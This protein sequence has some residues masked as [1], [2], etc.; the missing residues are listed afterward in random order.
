MITDERK[1]NVLVEVPS[2]TTH[3][4]VE[5]TKGLGTGEY[6][7]TDSYFFNSYQ[8]QAMIQ[9]EPEITGATSDGYHTF[10]EL[11]FHRMILFSVI[12]NQNKEN[13]WKARNH[14][15]GSMFGDNWFI[16][17]IKTPEGQYTYHYH[18][19][20]WDHFQVKELDFA[21]E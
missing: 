8:V 4:K 14:S 21:P 10:D 7:G 13:A 9:K 19:E 20:Y 1:I 6:C 11:Y 12:C 16:V 17:G 3:L 5:C 2:N 15:D 18:M